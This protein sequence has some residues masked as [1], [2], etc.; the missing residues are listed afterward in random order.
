MNK[1]SFRDDCH[2]FEVA[3]EFRG[4]SELAPWHERQTH[5]VAMERSGGP[6]YDM[7]A[8]LKCFSDFAKTWVKCQYKVQSIRLC[9]PVIME[10]ETHEPT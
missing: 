4:P 8:A 6:G 3:Y 1:I 7:Q 2:L 5:V 9:G 10:D